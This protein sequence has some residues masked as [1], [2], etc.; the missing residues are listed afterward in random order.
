MKKISIGLIVLI[1]TLSITAGIAATTNNNTKFSS[2]FKKY[3][4]DCD[5]YEETVTSEFGGKTYE[6]H[7]KIIGWR[8][9]FCRYQET[10]SSVQEKYMLDC[11]FSAVQLDELYASIKS[12]SKNQERF[13]LETFGERVDEKGKVEYVKLGTMT[14]KGNKAYVTWAKYQNNPYFCKPT[15]LK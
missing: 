1:V 5:P 10:M 7:R 4:K 8:N 3:F 15:K 12:R 14:I 6:T 11:N 2:S 9:G 13:E